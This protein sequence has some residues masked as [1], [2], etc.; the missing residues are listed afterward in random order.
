MK[1]KFNVTKQL[2]IELEGNMKDIFA[3]IAS[4]QEV[5]SADICGVCGS[6]ET[7]FRV[8]K[9]G[10]HSYYEQTC[11]KP[12]CYA[13]LAYGQHDGDLG[14]LFPKRKNK[15]GS[16]SQTRGWEKWTPDQDNEDEEESPKA[17]KKS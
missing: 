16:F 1:A 2:Q 6:N 14:T 11:V 3:E 4:Y 10:K 7:R 8:R 9:V 17:K 13:R 15:D 12:G 5:F